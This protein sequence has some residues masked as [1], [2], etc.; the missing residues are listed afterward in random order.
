M[1]MQAHRCRHTD[2]GTLISND[3]FICK[4]NENVYFDSFGIEHVPEEIKEFIEELP[5]NKNIKPNIFRLQKN[6]SV[7]CG[8]FCIGFYVSM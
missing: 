2:V 1:Q 8:H 7:M 6:N 4:K 3:C 5:G